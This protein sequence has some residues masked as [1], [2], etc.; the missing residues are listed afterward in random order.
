MQ[1]TEEQLTSFIELHKRVRGL[2]LDRAEALRLATSLVKLVKMTYEP[3][4]KKDFAKYSQ[5]VLK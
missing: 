4:S 2:V 1:F 3:M 5:R